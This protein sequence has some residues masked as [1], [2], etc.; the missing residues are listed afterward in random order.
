MR[1]FA[2]VGAWLCATAV[3][4]SA[5]AAHA[6]EGAQQARLQTAALF[7]F[8]HGLAL[9]VLAPRVASRAMRI[10]LVALLAGVLLF[11]GSLAAEALS[12]VRPR[13]APFGG[14]LLIAGWLLLGAA[15]LKKEK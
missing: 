14:T 8:G 10:G 1:A 7:A 2:A 15:M 9:V 5:Y 4:T 6:V 12:G 13:L 3:A 11:S